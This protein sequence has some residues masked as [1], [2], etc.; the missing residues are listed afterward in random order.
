[1]VLCFIESDYLILRFR[2]SSKQATHIQESNPIQHGEKVK[3]QPR[4]HWSLTPHCITMQDMLL[5][6]VLATIP[7][8][9]HPNSTPTSAITPPST[10]NTQS[11]AWS[12]SVWRTQLRPRTSQ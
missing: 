1:M 5:W 11:S 2:P 6:L 4:C 7:T 8:A 3:D 12:E 10:H 9:L